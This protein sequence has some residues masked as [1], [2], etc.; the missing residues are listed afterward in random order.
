MRIPDPKPGLVFRYAYTWKDQPSGTGKDRPPCLVVAI[1]GD[2]RETRVVIVPITHSPPA[3]DVAAIEIPPAVKDRL[4]LDG[5]RS[6]IILT[7]ANI[8]VWPSPDLRPIPGKPDHV[9]YGLLPLAL[10]NRIREQIA[11]AMREKR[12]RTLRRE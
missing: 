11:R 10:T 9:A 4:G 8:D 7:E 5:D 3:A 6:W 1:R 12:L 2:G